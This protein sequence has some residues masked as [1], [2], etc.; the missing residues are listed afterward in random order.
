MVPEWP[1]GVLARWHVSARTNGE[2]GSGGVI[3]QGL[4]PAHCSCS[5]CAGVVDTT[6]HAYLHCPLHRAPRACLLQA[7]DA[8]RAGV[9]ATDAFVCWSLEDR[10]LRRRGWMPFGGCTSTRR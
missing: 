10:R 7:V 9:Q 8:W 5:T 6:M 1:A 2:W 4:G 3:R